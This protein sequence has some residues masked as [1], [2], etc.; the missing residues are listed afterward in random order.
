[1]KKGIGKSV[2]NMMCVDS[3]S[4]QPRNFLVGSERGTLAS[5]ILSLHS[6]EFT[7]FT[8]ITTSSITLAF[9]QPQT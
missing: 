2:A 4:K 6:E 8:T 7:E 3:Y 1:M 9:L 5:P